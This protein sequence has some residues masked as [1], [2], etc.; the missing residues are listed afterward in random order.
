MDIILLQINNE[1]AYKLIEDLEALNI[2]KVL[3]KSS[4]AGK[5]NLSQKFA[6]ALK[7]TDKQYQDLQNQAK[8]IRNEWERNI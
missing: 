7:L 6:G 5:S 4:A 8:E 3:K 1:K 2:V